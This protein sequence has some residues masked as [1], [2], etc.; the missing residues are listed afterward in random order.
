[1]FVRVT[2]LDE[3]VL[4]LFLFVPGIRSHLATMLSLNADT[5]Q[6]IAVYVLC[7]TPSVLRIEHLLEG[8]CFRD[9]V[10]SNQAHH[11]CR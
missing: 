2:A 6:L 9:Y 3:S 5:V 4:L 8:T 10:N 1:M 11:N 7:V